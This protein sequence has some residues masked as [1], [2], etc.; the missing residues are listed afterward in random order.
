MVQRS[1]LPSGAGTRFYVPPA[2][3]GAAQQISALTRSGDLRDAALLESMESFPRAVWFTRGTPA[4][5]SSQVQQT[6]AAGW[7]V[8]ASD[9]ALFDPLWGTDDPAAGT[10]FAQQA[11]QLAQLASPALPGP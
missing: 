4:Q 10:W 6:M 2:P 1:G 5:V 11:L 7:P 8:T 9:Q 3:D